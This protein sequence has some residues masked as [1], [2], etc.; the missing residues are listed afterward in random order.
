MGNGE[1][2][3]RLGV[4]PCPA[5]GQGFFGGW[6]SHP[7]SCSVSEGWDESRGAAGR[8]GNPAKLLLRGGEEK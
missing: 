2:T 5:P 4:R 7:G 1:Q 6:Q 8:W 3:G